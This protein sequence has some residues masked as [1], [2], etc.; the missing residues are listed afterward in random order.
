MRDEQIVFGGE[1]CYRRRP[2]DRSGL[3][4]LRITIGLIEVAG[5]VPPWQIF[6]CHTNSFRQAPDR[7]FMRRY[8]RT[9]GEEP[10]P[11]SKNQT[12]MLSPLVD[13]YS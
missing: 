13:C 1:C 10:S 3:D 2:I 9:G 12:E 4:P 11:E 6:W 8:R 5:R 7:G